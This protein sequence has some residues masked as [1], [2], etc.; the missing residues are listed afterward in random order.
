MALSVAEINHQENPYNP[1]NATMDFVFVHAKHN[2]PWIAPYAEE[3]WP[4]K[5][6]AEFPTAR[7]L[8]FEYNAKVKDKRGISEQT[9]DD[10]TYAWELLDFLSVYRKS[11]AV[12]NR[13]ILFIC[14][15]LGEL[16]CY[17]A[18]TMSTQRLELYLRDLWSTS[19]VITYC[20]TSD[21]ITI[22]TGL[23]APT[24]LRTSSQNEPSS[25]LP[26]L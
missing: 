24:V 7:I 4:N 5:L 25:S 8:T 21:S 14:H 19:K 15:G 2:P 22:E 6:A 12:D 13:P 20:R 23:L 10:N 26:T 17:K 11:D 18:L 1:E 16:V 9:S 3:P